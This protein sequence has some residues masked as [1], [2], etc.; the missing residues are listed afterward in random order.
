MKNRRHRP[1]SYADLVLALLSEKS[2]EDEIKIANALDFDAR[3]YPKKR[4]ACEL[5]G[6]MNCVADYYKRHLKNDTEFDE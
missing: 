2:E 1:I 3:E 5:C 6:N 4:E